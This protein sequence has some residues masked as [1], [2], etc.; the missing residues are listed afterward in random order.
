MVQAC[1][2]ENSG[3]AHKAL[4]QCHKNHAMCCSNFYEAMYLCTLTI[5]LDWREALHHLRKASPLATLSAS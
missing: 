3:A 1:Q 2:K 5:R 4:V